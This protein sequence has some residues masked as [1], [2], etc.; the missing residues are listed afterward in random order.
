MAGADDAHANTID[1]QELRTPDIMANTAPAVYNHAGNTTNAEPEEG[2]GLEARMMPQ[3]GERQSSPLSPLRSPSALTSTVR[4]EAMSLPPSHDDGKYSSAT[5]PSGGHTTDR[6]PNGSGHI[7]IH[8]PLP[9]VNQYGRSPGKESRTFDPDT[10]SVKNLLPNDLQPGLGIDAQIWKNYLEEATQHDRDNIT[11]WNQNM[12]VILIFAALF[13][14]ILTAFIIEF[15]KNLQPDPQQTTAELLL[16]ITQ[17]LQALAENEPRLSS[18]S[19]SVSTAEHCQQG[20]LE[21]MF[22]GSQA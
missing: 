3:F 7:S 2:G 12:D 18:Q 6:R 15:Y 19:A 17:I 14:A 22:F 20:W 4:G 8:A 21:S 13:S 10:E 9:P 16:N 1:Q 11:G 5:T